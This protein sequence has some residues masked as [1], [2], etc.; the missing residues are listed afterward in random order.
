MVFK[1]QGALLFAASPKPNPTY[2]LCDNNKVD[3]SLE[4]QRQLEIHTALTEEFA[5]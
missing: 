5:V 1:N 2:T 3:V 4:F